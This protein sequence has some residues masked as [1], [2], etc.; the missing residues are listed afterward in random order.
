MSLKDRSG[1]ILS[2]KKSENISRA[3]RHSFLSPYSKALCPFPP[4]FTLARFITVVTSTF[5]NNILYYTQIYSRI[6]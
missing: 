1:F 2:D 6:I 5:I 4:D 3:E